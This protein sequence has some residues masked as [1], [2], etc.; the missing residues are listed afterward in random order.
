M[1]SSSFPPLLG[2]MV[3]G[4]I[5]K[6]LITLVYSTHESVVLCY[7]DRLTD[8]F[9]SSCRVSCSPSLFNKTG[10]MHRGQDCDGS[11]VHPLDDLAIRYISMF[12]FSFFHFCL[13][14]RCFEFSWNSSSVWAHRTTTFKPKTLQC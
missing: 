12:D 11:F 9:T 5:A 10:V 6:E 4:I 2:S 8:H 13:T 3:K 7:S 1:K 14:L